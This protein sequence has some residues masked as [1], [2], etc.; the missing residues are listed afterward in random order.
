MAVA[1]K[2]AG[3][4]FLR[5]CAW[6]WGILGIICGMSYKETDWRLG[7]LAMAA[8]FLMLPAIRALIS[9]VLGFRL[10][11]P[12]AM[13]AVV[14]VI[15]MM[16]GRDISLKDSAKK[17]QQAAIARE[18]EKQDRVFLERYPF[19]S[20]DSLHAWRKSAADSIADPGGTLASFLERQQQAYHR[21]LD[22]SMLHAKN[23]R[24]DSILAAKKRRADSLADLREARRLAELREIRRLAELRE[25]RRLAAEQKRWSKESYRA[26]TGGGYSG[27]RVIHTGPR[28]GR[29]YIN[30]NGN[31]TYVK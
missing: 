7:V 20:R 31:K 13:G 18:A 10:V 4:S 22:D 25:A 3:A 8:G 28:G 1:T 19:V 6:I 21:R 5:F 12:M 9:R 27:G 17:E 11:H 16:I 23:W 24:K 26:N 29:Y 15:V 2:P 30:S 14:L